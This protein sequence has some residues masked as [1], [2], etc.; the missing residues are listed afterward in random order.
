MA[1]LTIYPLVR[2]SKYASAIARLRF[3]QSMADLEDALDQQRAFWKFVGI[4]T[5][6]LTVL[7]IFLL[8]QGQTRPRYRY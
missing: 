5:L 1:A 4:M 8:I 2:L 6:I 3:S 7:W